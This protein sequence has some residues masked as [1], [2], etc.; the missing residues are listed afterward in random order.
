[1]S[2]FESKHSKEYV[3]DYSYLDRNFYCETPKKPHSKKRKIT[4]EIFEWLDII[5]AALVAVI[6]AFTFFF[7]VA[8]IEGESM[9]N[10]FFEGDR[11]II[12]KVSYTPKYGDV[13]VIS[14]NYN[15]DPERNDKESQPII[16]RVIATAGQTVKID[17][18]SGVVFVDDI[19]LSENYTSTPT[20]NVVDSVQAEKLKEGISVPPN[21]VFVLGDNRNNS[22]DSRS[23]EIGNRGDG[24]ID[25]K[26][27]LGKVYFRVF[28]FSRFGGV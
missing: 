16:K 1:M 27:I 9:Q 23:P 20:N 10:S 21:C 15:I 7:R 18:D 13:V 24:M 3:D 8:T 12:S 22:L 26:Y 19:A 25:V 17:F 4:K 11:V 14:R 5:V 6:I 2:L 28:P